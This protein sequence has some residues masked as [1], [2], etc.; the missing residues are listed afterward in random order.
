MQHNTPIAIH[1]SHL[2]H[3]ILIYDLIHP[4]IT[5]QQEGALDLPEQAIRLWS[6]WNT[7][8][9]LWAI[10][11]VNKFDTI[12]SNKDKSFGYFAIHS[13]GLYTLI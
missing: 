5:Q 6:D 11:R 10:Q 9:K 7:Q 1:S 4:I 12:S 13:E 2:D 3:H 8:L